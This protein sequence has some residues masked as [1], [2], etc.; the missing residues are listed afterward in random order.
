MKKRIALGCI[1]VLLFSLAGCSQSKE[2]SVEQLLEEELSGEITVSCY[3]PMIYKD[4]FEK[5]AKSFEEKHPGTKINV[6]TFAKMPDIK[7]SEDSKIAVVTVTKEEESQESADYIGKI[8][9]ELMGGGG[10]DL[11][12]MDIL[13]FYKYADSGLLENLQNYMDADKGFSE[14]DYRS[15]IIEAMKYK[16]G[17]YLMP[18]DYRFD[19][20]AYDS[21]LLRGDDESRLK[22]MADRISYNELFQIEKNSFLQEN[23]DS[24]GSV[25]MLGMPADQVMLD[26][27]MRCDYD[28]YIDLENRKVSLND[29]RFASLLE[30]VK[31]Y[32]TD[33]YLRPNTPADQL[34]TGD[35]G[36]PFDMSVIEKL[37]SEEFFFKSKSHNSLREEVLRTEGAKDGFQSFGF[38]GG[39]TSGDERNDKILGLLSGHNGNKSFKYFNALGINSNSSNKALAWSFLKYLLSEE[40]QNDPQMMIIGLPVNNAAREELASKIITSNYGNEASSEDDQLTAE[41]ENL[42]K[43]YRETVESLSDTLNYWPIQDDTIKE[44]IQQETK[45]FFDGSSSS[46]EVAEALQKKI[47]LYLNE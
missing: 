14:G 46:G 12:V 5:A 2:A 19:Y 4:F 44:M 41:Q 21:S 8:N 20:I 29:G 40:I 33:G 25:R 7:T 27:L 31:Q 3:D 15:N 16:G 1:F 11:L 32:G 10:P 42:V 13:P 22:A 30:S 43:R 35:T 6:E 45:R 37:R 28:E 23:S 47:E 26:E 39:I 38:G 17:Q 9:T 36:V 24:S 18:L 34:G